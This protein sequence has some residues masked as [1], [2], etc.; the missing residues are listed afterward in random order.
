[1]LIEYVFL[2]P[3][4]YIT[5]PSSHITVIYYLSA[6]NILSNLHICS[7][8][9][10]F[11]CLIQFK[12]ILFQINMKKD[13]TRAAGENSPIQSY[14]LISFLDLVKTRKLQNSFFSRERN[15]H[16]TVK[17]F[18]CNCVFP[19]SSMPIFFLFFASNLFCFSQGLD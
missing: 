2:Y 12:H 9:L 11:L 4:C 6:V 19:Y 5:I 17:E 3:I 13:G 1:M 16:S 15:F 7:T 8:P 18:Y 10:F 14:C